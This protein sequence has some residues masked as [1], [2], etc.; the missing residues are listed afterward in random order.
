MIF[1][2]IIQFDTRKNNK[3][4][5]NIL[6]NFRIISDIVEKANNT[7]DTYTDIQSILMSVIK[8][9]D[10]DEKEKKSTLIDF[11]AAGIST[12]NLFTFLIQLFLRKFSIIK[13]CMFSAKQQPYDPILFFV[14]KFRRT[15]KTF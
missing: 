8:K 10:V 6:I 11:I 1:F 4:K 3:R 7:D 14:K 15:R 2:S 13:K 5:I 12:V 9:P